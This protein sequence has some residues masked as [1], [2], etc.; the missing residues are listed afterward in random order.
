MNTRAI[1]VEP[2]LNGARQ[3][4]DFI[5]DGKVIIFPSDCT[6]GFATNALVESSVLKIYEIKK[7]DIGKPLCIL[8]TKEKAEEYVYMNSAA[9]RLMDEFWPGPLGIILKKKEI[10]PDFVTAG[11]NSVALVCMDPFT[12][13]MSRYADVP[14]CVTSVNLS[15][16]PSISNGAAAIEYFGNDVGLIVDGG[17][18]RFAVNT[19]LVDLTDSSQAVIL[20]KG[21]VSVEDIRKSEWCQI[22]SE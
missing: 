16:E 22:T 6:Y 11:K 4:A 8:T 15:G 9:L 5:V 20:R 2:T 19:T 3:A 21:P 13:A 1:V 17:K 12:V 7:R 18:C 14:I 10:I